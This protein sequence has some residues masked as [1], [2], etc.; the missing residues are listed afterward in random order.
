MTSDDLKRAIRSVPDFPKKGILFRDITPV[1]EHAALFKGSID[2]LARECADLAPA[3]VV[4]L[5]ARGFIF[6]AALAYRIGAGFVPVR[7]KG[8]LPFRT[9]SHAYDL[10]YG[11]AEF[12]IHC[13]SIL[14]GEPVIL[15]DDVLATGGT[16]RAALHLLRQ[17]GANVLRTLFV[18]EIE[19]LGG[20]DQLAPMEVRSLVR[21]K[22]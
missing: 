10:E 20:R 18:V 5:D 8:K 19:G 7:K 12:E 22:E 16:A 13:D 21:F 2:L 17:L 15:V 6:G 9:I 11:S 14:P 1:L 3:K 4:G